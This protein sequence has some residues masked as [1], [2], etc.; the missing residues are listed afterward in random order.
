VENPKDLTPL[1][2]FLFS[3]EI[4][5]VLDNAES[6]LD[7]QGT[8]AREIFDIVDELCQ[9][10]TICL[11]ITSR[12]TT[13]PRHCKHPEI[14]TLSMEAARDMF[15]SIHSNGGQCDIIDNLLRRLDFHALSIT[16]LAT[17]ACHNM[18]NYNELAE[19][20]DMQRAQLLRT[21][22]NES[23]AATIELS[24]ASPTFQKLGADARELLGVV[25]FFPQGIDERN[26]DWFF[27]TIS[28]RKNIFVKFRNLSLTHRSSE[29]ITM[30]APIRDYLCLPDPTSS[31]LL[32]AVKD[33]YFSRLSVNICPDK[34]GF[35]E[36][37]WIK[38]EDVN[39]EHLLNVFTGASI[40]IN[41]NDAWIVCA[42]FLTHLYWH[43]QRPTVLGPKITGLPDDHPFKHAC[44]F[45]LS[46]SFEST[47]N[48]AEQKC[49]LSHALRLAKGQGNNVRV[50]FTLV[51]L[52]ETNRKL[53]LYE[54][55][56]QRAKEALEIFEQLGD[57]SGQAA[58]L[59]SLAALLHADE[60]LDA[61]L[62]AASRAM[63]LLPEQGED[64]KVCQSH[65]LLGNIFHSKGEREKAIHHFEAALGI[66]STF[67]WH[68]QL[69]R[70]HKRLAELFLEKDEFDDAQAHIEQSKSHAVEG[71][72]NLG[73]AMTLQ[74]SI[75]SRQGRLEDARSEALGALEI[76]E[77][78]GATEKV[79][80]CKGLLHRIEA[81][82]QS[83][84][85][86]PKVS[87][88][89]Q[90]LA[91][92]QIFLERCWQG[93][94]IFFHFLGISGLV[95]YFFEREPNMLQ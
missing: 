72:Y 79:E 60:R 10:E 18:W 32:C 41:T 23:L 6:I 20:W 62:E 69:F 37:Q 80:Y 82:M 55:G 51:W 86:F 75:W 93:F 3:H 42:H 25:A 67:N 53:K 13:I 90:N 48:Y 92:F 5:I 36:G 74:S 17:T 56:V 85:G 9:F 19:E 31:P 21:D 7:P 63:K 24:L 87:K 39:V 73:F 2:H 16:L 8:D 65:R 34:P 64:L 22:Y 61:A 59:I 33:R 44:L 68:T 49:L 66:S 78:L 40:D 30:L 81:R 43:K 28:D 11:L 26:L 54:E 14:P 84:A 88:T 46:K 47:G 83:R 27:P 50:A 15:Y 94:L 89:T 91:A 70:V 1:R 45:E 76:F 95:R 58:S 12:L 57:I 38:S 71:T 29:F 4:F 52:T 35:E 77:R